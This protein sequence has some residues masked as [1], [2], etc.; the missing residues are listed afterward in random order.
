MFDRF[1]DDARGV[2][3]AAR[4]EAL[5]LGHDAIGTEHLLLGLVSAHPGLVGRVAPGAGI[6]DARILRVVHGIV[7]PGPR[8]RVVSAQL[9]FMPAAKVVLEK[10]LAEAVALG[11]VR[12]GPLHLLLGL[13][14]E[15]R[16]VAAR[17]LRELGVAPEVV[18]AAAI[19]RR[20]ARGD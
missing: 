5:R 13:I 11:H 14:A 7:V 10:T 12:I 9:P 20:G 8:S 4:D 3:G 17:A 2:L 6:D 1:E 15:G 18:R 16:G 19:A